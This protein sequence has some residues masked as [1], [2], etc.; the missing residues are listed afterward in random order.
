M[1]VFLVYGI[2]ILIVS[3][4]W[5]FLS[6]YWLVSIWYY[7]IFYIRIVNSVLNM[8]YI[9]KWYVKWFVC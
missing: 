7:F 8:F 5:S 2:V 1:R 3:F 4:D 9:N 6:N